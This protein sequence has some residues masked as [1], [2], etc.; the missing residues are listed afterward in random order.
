MLTLTPVVCML[1]AIGFST[2]LDNYLVDT[3]ELPTNTKPETKKKKKDG[4]APKKDVRF[5]EFILF[6]ILFKYFA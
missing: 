4:G 3:E 6:C 2:T 1:A 5:R